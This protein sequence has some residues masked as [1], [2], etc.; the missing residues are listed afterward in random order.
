MAAIQA[1][2]TTKTGDEIVKAIEGIYADRLVPTSYIYLPA[3]RAGW[4]YKVLP[5]LWVPAVIVSTIYS[6]CFNETPADYSDYIKGNQA[7]RKKD[8]N[9]ASRMKWR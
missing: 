9:T 1:G 7:K 4:V 8:P 5:R 3:R 6:E 2:V